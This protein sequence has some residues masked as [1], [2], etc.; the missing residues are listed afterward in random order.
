MDVFNAAEY[1]ERLQ[2]STDIKTCKVPLPPLKYGASYVFIS[3]SHKDYKQVYAVLADLYEQGIPFWYDEGIKLG[4]AWDEVVGSRIRDPKCSGTIFFT[5]ENFFDSDSVKKEIDIIV[6]EQNM[7]V[8]SVNLSDSL[9]SVMINKVMSAKINNFVNSE[10]VTQE[11][12]VLEEWK[13]RLTNIFKDT[14]RYYSLYEPIK[15]LIESIGECFNIYANPYEFGNALFVTG[16]AEI[17]FTNGANYDGGFCAGM[18]E[19]RG[20]LSTLTNASDFSVDEMAEDFVVEFCGATTH[21]TGKWKNGKPNGHG[22]MVFGK[23]MEYRGEWHD[24][25][26]DGNGK[27]MYPSGSIYDG[28]WMYGKP[29]G[30]G[31]LILDNG[32]RYEGQWNDVG[33]GNGTIIYTNKDKYVGRWIALS[34]HGK[35]KMEY[36]DGSSFE[37][38]WSY[39]ERYGNGTFYYKPESIALDTGVHEL[40]K[41]GRDGSSDLERASRKG[42]WEKDVLKEG[43]G[44]IF[45]EDGSCYNGEIRNDKRHGVG[46]YITADG[47]VQDGAFENDEFLG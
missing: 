24:G 36:S 5:S 13:N 22:V 21:Y 31:E 8:I 9:P 30:E 32:T 2:E 27:V 41:K 46:I 34:P 35:G 28:D 42:Y 7:E 25:K 38:K 39:G 3:Y 33:R 11:R 40:I 23:G 47:S 43:S 20:E 18:F 17:K 12:E 37:G 44:Y 45:Y 16:K 29:F 1:K 26:A 6:D 15:T 14:K 19:G 10:E 4:N